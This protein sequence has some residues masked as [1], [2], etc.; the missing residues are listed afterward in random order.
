MELTNVQYVGAGKK[1][2]VYSSEDSSLISLDIINSSFGDSQ[3]YIEYFIYDEL[4]QLIDVNYNFEDYKL[5]DQIGSNSVK[6]SSIALDP[7]SDV[8]NAGY[9][10]GIVTIQYNFLKKLFNSSVNTKYWIKD[11]STSRLELKLTSQTLSGDDIKS[12]VDAYQSYILGKNYYS[13]FY[14][15]FS[16]N[17]LIIAV[18]AAYVQESDGESYLLIKLY[19]PLPDDYDIKS[20]LWIVDKIAESL[21]YRIEIQTQTIISDDTNKLRGPNYNVK[22]LEKIGQATSFYSYNSLF[23][24]P[25]SSSMQKIMSYYEDKAISINVDFTN[26]ENFIH[27]SSATE[28]VNNFVYKLDLIQR[29]QWEIETQKSIVTAANVVASISASINSI[30]NNID[31]II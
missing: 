19:E 27:F 8:K 5:E 26:F 18:N 15:N 24:S 20:Q 22:A 31:R 13:D 6:Y 9:D 30:Q 10:R 28:R 29:Y 4:D 25:V 11:I 16:K 3:D 14:L 17:D 2:Q 21:S 7:L 1:S 23:S 12:G